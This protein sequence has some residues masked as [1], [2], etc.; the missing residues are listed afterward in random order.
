VVMS[1]MDPYWFSF[2]MLGMENLMIQMAADPAF[3]NDIYRTYTDWLLQ[4]LG[5]VVEMGV[6]WDAIWFFSDMGY[7][8]GP[9]FSPA[10]YRDYMAEQHSRVAEFCHSRGK[11]LLLHSD[12]NMV[13]LIPGLIEAGFDA[14]QPLEARA[15][16]D[17]R[18]LKPRY[19]EDVCFF[20]NISADVLARGDK[21]EI[22]EEVRT[23]VTAA[24]EGGGYIYH[25]D[26]SIPPSVSFDSYRLA[27][28]CA[29]KNGQF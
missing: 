20:G 8:N 2:R 14:I 21:A 25:S 11:H 12:G 4:M 7:R 3:I 1:P 17:V 13:K 6:E 23:K 10:F 28:E 15:G 16:N 22:E 26:H 19:G 29:R 5:Q 9:M 18:E 27:L 24:K